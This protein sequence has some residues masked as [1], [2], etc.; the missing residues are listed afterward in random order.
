MEQRGVIYKISCN[1]CND[2]RN[3]YIG[4]TKRKL[5]ARLNEHFCLYSD[6]MKR[7]EVLKHGL[8][9]HETASRD[10]WNFEIVKTCKDK[11][12]RKINESICIEKTKPGLNKKKGITF[13]R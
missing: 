12:C 1:I 3:V 4:E 6:D 11:I 9:K 2:T 8:E 7:L 10:I 5:V 13:I